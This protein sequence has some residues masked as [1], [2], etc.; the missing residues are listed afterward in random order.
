MEGDDSDNIPGINGAGL[1]TILKCFP[2]LADERQTSLQEIYNYAENNK[3][4]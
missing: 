4:K 2:F 3:G 1:K